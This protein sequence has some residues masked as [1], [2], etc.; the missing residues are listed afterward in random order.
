MGLR[1]ITKGLPTHWIDG[2]EFE[3]YIKD[4]HGIEISFCAENVVPGDDSGGFIKELI[5]PSRAVQSFGYSIE[6]AKRDLGTYNNCP[7]D[8]AKAVLWIAVD[9]GRFPEGNYEIQFHW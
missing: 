9:E 2:S 4:E 8:L 5:D 7:Q 6:A 3:S 1:I